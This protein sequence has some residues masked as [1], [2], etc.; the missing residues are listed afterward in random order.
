MMPVIAHV[1]GHLQGGGDA[2][3]TDGMVVVAA[4]SV[5]VV[6]LLAVTER[7]QLDAPRD[8]VLPMGVVLICT[9]IGPVVTTLVG[10]WA[11]WALPMLIVLL[12]SVLLAALFPVSLP[13]RRVAGGIG[14]ITIVAALGGGAVLRGDD[15]MTFLPMAD[16]VTIAIDD[17]DDGDSVEAGPLS[18][19]V[20][21]EGGSI[22]PPIVPES[23]LPDDATELGHVVLSVDGQR[24][25]S[26][27]DRRCRVDDPCTEVTFD[28]VLEPGE[29]RVRV[30]FVSAEGLPFAPLVTE[31][32]TVEV[33]EESL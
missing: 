33:A 19:T 25:S 8:L 3:A 23:Q 29:R 31:I 13:S 27:D 32:L 15:E 22:G 1:G 2:T 26:S 12:L 9:S 5:A 21:V 20:V 18:L 14:A 24:V 28:L 6:F 30:E 16:G 7:L 17:L 4:S 11:P 10:R